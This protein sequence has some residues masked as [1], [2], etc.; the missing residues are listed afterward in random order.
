MTP[1]PNLCFSTGIRQRRTRTAAIET[2]QRG[3]KNEKITGS[4]EGGAAAAAMK[5][6]PKTTRPLTRFSTRRV[7]QPVRAAEEKGRR[8]GGSSAAQNVLQRMEWLTPF[9]EEEQKGSYR[10][11]EPVKALQGKL[12]IN[13][14]CLS[15]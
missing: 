1:K 4:N 10:L 7:T 13:F 15:V 3:R 9:L 6:V 14:T 8:K 11:T 12:S 5:Q 2:R